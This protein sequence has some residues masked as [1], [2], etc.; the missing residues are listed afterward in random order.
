M[1]AKIPTS[2]STEHAETTRVASNVNVHL[3]L[4]YTNQAEY[5]KVTCFYV[6]GKVKER[7]EVLLVYESGNSE[8]CGTKGVKRRF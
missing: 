7:E 1:N 4:P 5:A 6:G 3:N 8:P 2:A